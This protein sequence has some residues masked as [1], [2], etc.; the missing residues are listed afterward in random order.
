MN[1]CSH[2]PEIRLIW[3]K[4]FRTQHHAAK[5]LQDILYISEIFRVKICQSRGCMQWISHA[6]H[7]CFV[8]LVEAP[9]LL[10]T[11]DCPQYTQR[12]QRRNCN[13]VSIITI[14]SSYKQ[15][16]KRPANDGLSVKLAYSFSQW[17]TWKLRYQMVKKDADIGTDAD[18]HY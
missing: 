10:S 15:Q 13:Y 8:Y 3:G 4:C 14:A 16:Y 5:P 1:I 6:A 11:I 9:G 2:V 12:Q 7:S 18:S 17:T